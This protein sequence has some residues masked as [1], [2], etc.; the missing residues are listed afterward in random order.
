MS[1]PDTHHSPEEDPMTTTE[2]AGTTEATGTTGAT[3]G[4]TAATTT[5]ATPAPVESGPRVTTIV[6]G[7]VIAAIGAGLLAVALGVTFDLELAVIIVIAAAGLALV[8]GSIFRTR[9]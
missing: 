9:H 4:S 6:W 3:A 5:P 7:L 8:G 2:N 1:T